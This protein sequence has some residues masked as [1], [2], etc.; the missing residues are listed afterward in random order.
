M[1]VTINN[2]PAGMYTI[3][4][5]GSDGDLAKTTTYILNVPDQ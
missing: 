2:A 5:T 4:I 3:T 1:K